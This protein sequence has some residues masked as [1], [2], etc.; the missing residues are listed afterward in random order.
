[1]LYGDTETSAALRHE[2]PIVIGDPFLLV[3]DAE[4]TWIQAS[5]LEA[6]RLAACRPDAQLVDIGDLGVRELLQSDLQRD[7][8]MLELAARAAAATGVRE[9]I[10]DFAFPLGLADRLRADGITLRVD[11]AAITA[12]RRRKSAAEL[13]GIRRA[14]GAAGAA[15]TAAAELLARTQRDGDRLVLDGAALT[16]ERVRAAMRDA[17]WARG[18]IL[19]EDVIVASVWQ[20]FGHE[21]GSGPLPAALPIQVD[22]WPHDEASGCWADMTRTFVVC[23]EPPAQV[24]RQETL[25]R[26]VF[27]AAR[28]AVRSGVTGAELHAA[29]CERFEAEGYATQRTGPGEDPQE[30]FQFSLGHGVGLRVHEAPGLGQTGREPFVAGDVVA[31]EPGLWDGTVGGVRYE[32]LLLVTD[33]GCETLTDFGYSLDPGDRERPAVR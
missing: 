22:V 18:A 14:A 21:A 13:A 17:A 3:A 24:R 10:V 11:A 25:V 2:V 6:A 20:G 4:H 9:A 23:G 1:M 26:E 28:A 30:G 8:V 7:Q 29:V 27:D 19:P 16:A 32:D 5:S 33:H 31:I 15:M 12:R